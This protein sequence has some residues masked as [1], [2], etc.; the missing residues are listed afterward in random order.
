MET[1]YSKVFNG[2]LYRAQRDKDPTID[3]L[4]LVV[5]Y[6]VPKSKLDKGKRDFKKFIIKSIYGFL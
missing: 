1:K 5:F 3:L 2:Y 4:D 6:Q